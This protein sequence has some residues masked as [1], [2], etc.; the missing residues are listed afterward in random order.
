MFFNNN[1]KELVFDI[2][3]LSSSCKFSFS[4]VDMNYINLIKLCKLSVYLTINNPSESP[5][6]INLNK[7]V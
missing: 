1:L 6:I 3:S 7:L 4:R 2:F 5:D